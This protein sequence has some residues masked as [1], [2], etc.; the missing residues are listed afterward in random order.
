MH[1]IRGD[2]KH[3]SNA[4]TTDDVGH[5][6]RFPRWLYV[7]KVTVCQDKRCGRPG[8]ADGLAF[9]RSLCLL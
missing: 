2:A 1:R 9:L 4:K 8:Y 7:R 6:N 5:A 3:H